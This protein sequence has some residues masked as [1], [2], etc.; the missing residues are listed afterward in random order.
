[1][2]DDSSSL[3]TGQQH[4]KIHFDPK[5]EA[6]ALGKGGSEETPAVGP[7]GPNDL[8]KVKLIVIS[9]HPGYYEMKHGYPFYS[10][11]GERVPKQDRNGRPTSLEGWRNAGSLM[12]TSL[13]Q[14]YQL[15]TYQEVWFTNAIRCD[16]GKE[17]KI[18]AP[19][20][21]ACTSTWT[22][23]ELSYLDEAVPNAPILIAGSEAFKSIEYWATEF[24]RELKKLGG[25]S[26]CRRRDDLFWKRHPVVF[27]YNPASICRNEARIEED[28]IQRGSILKVKA[29]RPLPV[30]IGSPLWMFAN[31]LKFLDKFI[32]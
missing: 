21:R 12:R 24:F 9:D 29:V 25:L 32:P 17:K 14:M 20:L 5:C 31:D 8:T 23:N 22:I 16:P 11:D 27:T 28:F 4:P 6:C 26:A 2:N 10:N 13:E 18:G 3:Y 7:G 30:F 1:M 19:H 15:D